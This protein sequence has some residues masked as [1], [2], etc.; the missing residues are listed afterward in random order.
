MDAFELFNENGKPTGVWC[1][2]KCRKI[3]VLPLGPYGRM[4]EDEP[5]NTKEGAEA[6]CKT[7]ICPQCGKEILDRTFRNTGMCGDCDSEHYRQ[8][9]AERLQR[10]IEKATLVTDYEGPVYCEN[11]PSGDYGDHYHSDI[12]HLVDSIVD[13][14]DYFDSEGKFDPER[15]PEFAFCCKEELKLLDIDNAIERLTEDGYEGMDERLDIPESLRAAV[16]EFNDKNASALRVYNED[17]TRKLALRPLVMEAFAEI[18]EACD[19]ER[20]GP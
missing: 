17:P 12:N 7:P 6:C 8:Q 5:L 20:M 11:G 4:K 15:I 9:Q 18:K 3:R 16:Q 1:C 19:R 2:G 14:D 10:Q 13:S